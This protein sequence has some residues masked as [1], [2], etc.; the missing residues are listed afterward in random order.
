MQIFSRFFNGSNSCFLKISCL[1]LKILAVPRKKKYEYE[2]YHTLQCYLAVFC[3]LAIDQYF[4]K[5]MS[6]PQFF[7]SQSDL[8][9]LCATESH[10]WITCLNPHAEFPKSE[11]L[12]WNVTCVAERQKFDKCVFDWR[13][14]IN[15]PIPDKIVHYDPV[16]GKP[17]SDAD[18]LAA[19]IYSPHLDPKMKVKV[20]VT[21]LEGRRLPP[22]CDQ[23]RAPLQRCNKRA[24]YEMHLCKVYV[25]SIKH[26]TRLLYGQEWIDEVSNI[27]VEPKTK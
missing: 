21:G 13:R 17:L 24:G 26:C 5:S 6:S 12:D 14:E 15:D 16:N 3:Y 23:L 27:V 10:E 2:I 11:P 9:N 18:M 20:K 8:W 1:R 22:Q 4:K 25:E 19:K 7:Q